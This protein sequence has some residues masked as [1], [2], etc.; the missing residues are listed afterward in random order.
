[1]N[2]PVIPKKEGRNVCRLPPCPAYDVEGMESWLT[3][4]AAKGLMLTEDG[5][6]AGIAVFKQGAPQHV[7]YRL[8]AS[9]K[10]A[11]MWSDDG[12]EPD[13]E[14]VALSEKYGWAYIAKRGDFYIYRSFS[15][16]ARELNTDP[17]VHAIA[18][19]TVRKRQ[20]AAVFQAF[21]CLIIYPVVMM[22][23]E[24]LLTAIRARTWFFMFGALLLFWLFAASLAKAVHLG[25]LRRKLRID[26]V[27]NHAKDW[28]K[29]MLRHYAKIGL[30]IVL[31]AV[32]LCILFNRWSV[33]ALDEDKT[34]LADY[35]GDPPFATMADFSGGGEYR[36]LRL[37]DDAGFNAVKEWSDWLAPYN[38]DWAEHARISRPD[39]TV[40]EGGLY[41]DYHETIA[42]WIAKGLALE[43][44][45]R[46]KRGSRFAPLDTP[47]LDTD[48]AAAYI[49]GTGFPT[50][51]IQEGNVVLHVTFYQTSSSGRLAPEEWMYFVADS[52]RR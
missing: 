34:P 13:K 15:P 26:G 8:E 33:S 37:I 52:I 7:K 6:F 19:N 21:L 31:I 35:R 12:E 49:N 9:Q 39:G 22:R 1:M 42:P 44:Y 2:M 40:L 17:E 50:L 30:R 5:I 32:W 4:M 10:S 29:H 51:V 48:Y 14:A 3:D 38:I 25:R 41:V 45:R 18:L 36:L 20:H 46:D 28:R 11:G 47:P 16:G 43:Y 23:G 24:L 27:L